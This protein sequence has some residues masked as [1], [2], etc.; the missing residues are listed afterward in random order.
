VWFT[1]TD[2]EGVTER[3][4]V[5]ESSDKTLGLGGSIDQTL[6]SGEGKSQ[7]G[8]LRGGEE[9]TDNG[10]VVRWV[11]IELKNGVLRGVASGMMRD[12]IVD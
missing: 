5:S 8:G 1:S 12:D 4:E 7:V 11:V 3:E 9:T 6:M 2:G 10:G